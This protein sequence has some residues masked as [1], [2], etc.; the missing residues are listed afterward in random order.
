MAELRQNTWS[1]NAWSDQDYAGNIDYTGT[2][3]LMSWGSNN[4]GGLGQ[5]N[6]TQYSSP[7]QVTGTTWAN[8]QENG[9]GPSWHSLATKTDGTLWSWGMN[10][11][12]Q[13]GQNNKT[14]RSS[15]VQVPGTTWP[16]DPTVNRSTMVTSA[17]YHNDVIK[18]D[19]TLWQWG[20]NQYGQ[21]GQNNTTKYS[22]PVQVPG[23]TWKSI[24][25]GYA[26]SNGTKTD[27]TL[28]T[29]GYNANEG[30]LGHNNKTNYSSPKQIPGTTWNYTTAGTDYGIGV[31][32]DGTLWMWGDNSR[33][34][35]GQN[36]NTQYS[37]PKQIPGT[38]WATVK[39]GFD[40]VAATKTDGTLWSWGNNGA[41]VLG[42]NQAAAQV[43]AYSSPIQIPGTTWGTDF[44]DLSINYSKTMA[45]KTDGTLWA[46]GENPGGEL[47]QNNTISYSSPVQIPGTSWYK[48]GGGNKN[49]L[50]LTNN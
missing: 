24:N 8:V 32:T 34:Q 25:L 20:N 1:I 22:S 38:T 12:G 21:S 6:R 4:Y 9:G 46:I 50:A 30:Q 2:K 28:W 18:T 17:I 26:F 41:G 15:P 36:S 37:S 19:S 7:V 35:L 33:G 11:Q 3:E 45:I 43:E 39:G 14:N 40:Y 23:N 27:G 49:I 29:W 13:L 48:M 16:K 44:K 31:K 42:Q 10:H 5:N 47:A